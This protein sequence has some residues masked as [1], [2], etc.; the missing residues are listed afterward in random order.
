MDALSE[1]FLHL[2]DDPTTGIAVGLGIVL[3]VVGL[4]WSRQAL[5]DLLRGKWFD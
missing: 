4:M 3:L 2:Y 1:W 5:L